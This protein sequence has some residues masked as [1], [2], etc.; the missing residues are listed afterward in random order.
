[1]E[2]KSSKNKGGK[3]TS[4]LW[5][6]GIP[7]VLLI[8]LVLI[9]LQ[10]CANQKFTVTF[11]SNGGSA[12]ESVKV[13]KGETIEK[14]EDPTRE[15]YIF[16]GW[17]LDNELF[18]FTTKITKNITLKAKWS[19]ESADLTGISLNLETLT[20]KPGE[21]TTLVASFEPDNAEKV[22]L[23][24]SSSDE[25]IATVDENGVV[26]AIKEG[27]VTITV[28]TKDGKF[29]ATCELTV[30]AEKVAVTGVKFSRSSLSMYVGSTL[31][32]AN[33]VTVSPTNAS[34]K[35]LTWSSSN[36]GIATVNSKGVVTAKKTGKVT[37]TVKTVDGG[38][39]ATI[40]ITITEAP[41]NNVE[42]NSVTVSP[43]TL[44]MVIGET[45]KAT[46]TIEPANATNKTLTWTSS[47][48]N[49]VTVDANGNITAK[50]K[51]TATI[52][53]K[54]NNG[55]TAT[56]TVTV[57]NQDEVNMAKAK[58]LMNPKIINKANDDVNYTS[59]GCT[60]TASPNVTSTDGFSTVTNGKATKV[61]RGTTAS[62]VKVT[63]SITC[64][65]LKETKDV[66]HTVPAST[67][68]YTMEFNMLN[69]IK[70]K[71][72]TNY[73]IVKH[74]KTTVSRYKEAIGGAYSAE[75]EIG[76]LYDMTFDNDKNTTYAVRE[77]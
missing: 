23:V 16:D 51:G 53:V 2:G 71:N 65:S 35:G 63:Y 30:S 73:S 6:I 70:V 13:K 17:Y 37:I 24:W 55:K 1:M 62:S 43:S 42:V 45:K 57:K 50:G 54:T 25:S 60:I 15:D 36:T 66:T 46:A 8:A 68:T 9:L 31:K 48:P 4:L 77:G 19:L 21:T 34:N 59:T 10:A 67:Y 22:E 28:K 40:T 14:P 72:A 41:V 44:E 49:V 27:K 74:G 7:V 39:T 20:L 56:I 38:F 5:K 64:G 69:I 76:A 29:S 52:T 58:A 61:Y 11:D 26:T 47:D 18:D 33:Y 12:V 75:Y 32:L 3:D